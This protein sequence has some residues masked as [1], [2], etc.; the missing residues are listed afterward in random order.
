MLAN[1]L[2][3]SMADANGKLRLDSAE[4]R[5]IFGWIETAVKEGLTTHTNYLD[6]T[7]LKLLDNGTQVFVPWAI[8]WDA[9]PQQLLKTSKGKWRAMQLPAWTEGGLRAR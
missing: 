6:P 3:T 9:A 2:G 5:K 8:W 4:Y 1:Q 7:D